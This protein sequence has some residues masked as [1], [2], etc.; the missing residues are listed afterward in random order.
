MKRDEKASTLSSELPKC[1]TGIRG[2]DEIT[3]GGIPRG[4]PALICGG[5]GCGKTVFGTE[6]LVRGALQFDEPGVFMTFEGATS[7]NA[8]CRK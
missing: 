1:P 7:R 8:S 3:G 6:F 4:R 5:A 2:F